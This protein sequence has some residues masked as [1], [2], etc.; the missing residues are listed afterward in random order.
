MMSNPKSENTEFET[1]KPEN[2]PNPNH[3]V[4][5]DP[6]EVLRT[7]DG[8]GEVWERIVSRLERPESL[9]L[10][11]N[12]RL[13]ERLKISGTPLEAALRFPGAGV[14]LAFLAALALLCGTWLEGESSPLILALAPLCASLAGALSFR[15][16]LDPAA[17]LARASTSARALFF[18]RQTVVYGAMLLCLLPFA[19]WLPPSLWLV[20]L[21][22]TLFLNAAALAVSLRWGAG[23]GSAVGLGLWLW[24]VKVRILQT[25]DFQ[26]LQLPNF[27][28]NVWQALFTLACLLWVFYKSEDLFISRTFNL[29]HPFNHQRN[30]R[31]NP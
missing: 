28:P 6:L 8:G 4:K 11:W 12:L 3:D 7:G 15:L 21:L 23:V 26:G 27:P 29:D 14:L 19:L 10:P 13:L 20:W 1:T 24:L 31:S 17:E 18:A 22:P 9:V 2:H 30:N 25:D 5:T 16:E